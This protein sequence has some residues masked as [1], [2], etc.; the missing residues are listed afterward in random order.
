MRVLQHC[1][2]L[3]GGI[4][5]KVPL[6]MHIFCAVHLFPCRC[7]SSNKKLASNVYYPWSLHC[8][9]YLGMRYYH[10]L[11]LLR[12]AAKEVVFCYAVCK[13]KRQLVMG[14]LVEQKSSDLPVYFFPRKNTEKK[15]RKWTWTMLCK[16][17]VVAVSL[18]L[19]VVILLVLD[20]GSLSLGVWDTVDWRMQ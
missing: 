11:C 7:C 3:F 14:H 10:A 15:G 18:G 1:F 4:Y 13:E 20:A 19:C 8:F 9:Y 12:L 5:V 16:G 2:R 17:A 6:Q